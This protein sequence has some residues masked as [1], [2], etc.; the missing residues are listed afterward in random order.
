GGGNSII[1]DDIIQHFKNTGTTLIRDDKSEFLNFNGDGKVWA[2]FASKALPYNI[3]RNP[4]KYPSISEMTE[5]AI[6]ILSKKE[7]G[8]FLMVEG[9]QVDWAAHAN[10]A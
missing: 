9:S 2:L 6:D 10:D 8:F 3:D 5:K 4:E 1:T 7:N